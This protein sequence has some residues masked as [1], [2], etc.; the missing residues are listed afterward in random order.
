MRTGTPSPPTY[1]ARWL[2]DFL[3]SEGDGATATVRDSRAMRDVAKK[4]GA[5]FKLSP[6]GHAYIH[7]AMVQDDLHIGTEKSGHLFLREAH[8]SECP[9]LCLML[10]L[11]HLEGTLSQAVRTIREAYITS[12]EYN[13]RVDDKEKV[14]ER[15]K[16]HYKD[17]GSLVTI[18]GVLCEGPDWWVNIRPSNTEP[19]VRLTFE[20]KDKDTYD[21]L[22]EEAEELLK[23]FIKN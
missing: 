5:R 6:V 15:A 3:L 13:Y 21:N 23:P 14:I 19:L 4:H 9:L 22:K 12:P 20:A 2:A 18:D 10:T 7:R 17:K 16:E 1:S 11:K 8:Y